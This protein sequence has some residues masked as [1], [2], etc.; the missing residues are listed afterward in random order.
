V[1]RSWANFASFVVS[2]FIYQSLVGY[3]EAGLQPPVLIV[4]RSLKAL[5][6]L[7]ENLL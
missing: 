4:E 7:P 1:M 2:G 6:S 5:I 3:L